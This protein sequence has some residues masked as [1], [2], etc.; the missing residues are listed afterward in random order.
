VSVWRFENAGFQSGQNL[1]VCFKGLDIP[2]RDAALQVARDI[3]EVFGLLAVEVSREVEIKVIFFYFLDGNHS[4]KFGEFKL[5]VEDVHNLVNVLRAQAVFGAVFHE[6]AAGVNHEDALPGLG[7]LLVDND[8]A[9]GNAR[10]V[11]EIRGQADDAFDVA[12]A[13]EC[14]ANIRIGIAAK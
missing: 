5:P 6:A 13:N 11:K 9:G 14:A 2:V 8:D 1:P 10:T 3:L 4:R 12:L 7:V